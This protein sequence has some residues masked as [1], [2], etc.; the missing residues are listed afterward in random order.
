RRPEQRV[1]SSWKHLRRQDLP[2]VDVAGSDVAKA[3]SCSFAEFCQGI[4]RDGRLSFFNQMTVLLGLGCGWDLPP[5]YVPIPDEMMLENAKKALN[6]FFFV[7]I[8]EEFDRS[9]EMLQ[10][11]TGLPVQVL[12]RL[13]ATEASEKQ[14]DNLGAAQ[15]HDLCKFDA[16]L[17]KY[18]SDLSRKKK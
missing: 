2:L 4:L 11:L 13:N 16:A 12:P 9:C 6:R 8:T 7:G 5:G 18:G 17:Y 14:D 1:Y 3:R 10:G 15:L